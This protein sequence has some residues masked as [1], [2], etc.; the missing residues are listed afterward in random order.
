MIAL[1]S[2]LISF[3]FRPREIA[4]SGGSW[5]ERNAS[6]PEC[7]NSSESLP[8]FTECFAPVAGPCS[9]GTETG[10][11]IQCGELSLVDVRFALKLCA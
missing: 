2:A 6:A 3:A 1:V 4:P 9:V 7:S 5:V 10:L 11:V 8:C